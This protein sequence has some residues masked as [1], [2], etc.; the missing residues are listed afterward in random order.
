MPTCSVVLDHAEPIPRVGDTIVYQKV[1]RTRTVLVENVL[2][3]IKNGRVGFTGV[4]TEGPEA[5][6]DVWG[7]NDRVI[8]IVRTS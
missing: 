7:Y 3:D 5:T 2:A 1:H 6:L 4:V 8:P